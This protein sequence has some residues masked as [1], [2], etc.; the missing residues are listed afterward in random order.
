M[1]AVAFGT[2][3]PQPTISGVYVSRGDPA[4]SAT[5]TYSYV[6]TSASTDGKS[7]SV[8]SDVV[9]SDLQNLIDAG[10]YNT[11]DF[12]AE[13]GIDRYHVYR[14]SGGLYGFM[15]AVT[16][17]TS[18]QDDGS[19]TPDT[20]KT[21]PIEQ[22]PFASD[23]P[24]AVSYFEQRRMFAGTPLNPQK[25]WGTRSGTESDLAYSIPSRDDDA[26][27][28]RIA[29][30]DVNTIRHIVPMDSV[31]LLTSGGVWRLT[32]SDGG[33]IT[34]STLSVKPQSGVGANT[35]QPIIDD[36]TALYI[37]ARGG[38]IRELGYNWQ[39]QSFVSG[40]LSLRA[41]NLFDGYDITEL[42]FQ[43]APTP[44]MWGIS[45]AGILIGMTYVPI[46][47]CAPM[48]ALDH[49]WRDRKRVLCRRRDRG[50]HLCDREAHHWRRDSALCR[51]HGRG[52]GQ[53]AMPPC[54]S[55][56]LARIMATPQ[57]P[58]PV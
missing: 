16:T 13:T 21:P 2:T 3:L 46:R 52:C 32:S 42:A 34:P 5:K 26:I 53:I 7:E 54:S 27:S 11:I 36:T 41:P 45:T 48:D 9:A 19:I 24:G 30:R 22:Y 40:D 47:M 1:I 10:A 25:M 29:A 15:G 31:I 57:R 8:Q 56:A 33:A 14:L 37:A 39:V 50:S 17:G 23:Y 18:F 49:Q 28:F 20:G 4:S 43:R 35:A 51:A 6:V 58:L 44:I 55:I 38:H 12:G